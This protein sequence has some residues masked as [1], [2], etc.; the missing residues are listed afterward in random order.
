[1]K[2]SR[3]WIAAI[4]VVIS[5]SV[6]VAWRFLGPSSTEHP[7][8]AGADQVVLTLSGDPRTTL[9]FSWRTDTS[10]NSGTVR[11]HEI[12]GASRDIN[13]SFKTMDSSNASSV[14]NDPVVHRFSAVADGLLPG[15]LYEYQVLAG[16]QAEPAPWH[17]VR[18]APLD[19]TEKFSFLYLGDVQ[20]DVDEWGKRYEALV[21][22]YPDSRFAVF[23]GDLVDNGGVR[24]TWD[25][26][27]ASAPEAFA[28]LPIVPAVGN[29]ETFGG[30]AAL[31]DL[32]Y[33]LPIDAST[34][35]RRVYAFEYGS[36]FMAV[37]DSTDRDCIEE[38]TAWLDRRLAA[39]DAIWK[40]V[41][42]HHPVW[43]PA[44][45]RDNDW[46]REALVPVFDRHRI[47][48][49]LTGHDHS[50]ARTWPLRGGSRADGG[51]VYCVANAGGKHYQVQ[52]RPVFEKIQADVSTF[53][54]V[55]V[56][57]DRLVYESRTWDDVL[58][59]RFE[60]TRTVPA[61]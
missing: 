25:Q 51:T 58:I 43:S 59:D 46:L 27:F 1:M 8:F 53:Q 38:Q 23:T 17:A 45:R 56:S 55:S 24:A 10:V 29:H 33:L 5:I 37:L 30:G 34:T 4:V 9:G 54:V 20:V 41:V 11:I 22:T 6:M 12:G 32:M 39:S 47:D 16:D 57:S 36:L 31:F 26:V 13:A 48:L 50:Y 15:R 28:T 7:S 40:V 35:Q 52:P 60:R 21:T 19:K 44:P 3:L 61:L 49:V 42:F 2:R 14:V 18:T